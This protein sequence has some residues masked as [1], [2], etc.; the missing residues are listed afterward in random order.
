VPRDRISADDEVLN[1]VVVEKSQQIFEAEF[2]LTFAAMVAFGKFPCCVKPGRGGLALPE[3][4]V[5]RGSLSSIFPNR[6]ITS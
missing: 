2:T 4:Y 3:F 5:E 1:V 6:S